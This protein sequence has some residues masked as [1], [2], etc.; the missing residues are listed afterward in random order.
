M[1]VSLSI[2]T[3]VVKTPRVKQLSSAF[4][5]PISEKLSRQWDFQLPIEDR[6]WNVGL[7]VGPSGSG[8]SQIARKIYGAD[9]V[10]DA[11]PWGTGAVVDDFKKELSIT[12]ITEVCSA[13]GFNTVPS[14][15]RPFRTLSNGEQFRVDL[16]RRMLEAENDKTIVVDEFSSVVDRQ[17]AKIASNSV[18]KYVR[19]KGKQFVAI[20]CHYDVIDWLQPD[21]VFEPSTCEFRWRSL[22]CRPRIDGEIRETKYESWKKFA[23]YHYMTADLNKSARCYVFVVDEQEVGFASILPRPVSGGKNKG[24]VIW[25]FSRV[26]VLPDWQGM[27][28]A[29]VL[30]NAISSAYKTCNMRVRAYPAHP[31]YYRSYV[32]SKEWKCVGKFGTMTVRNKTTTGT[33][34]AQ[35]FGGRDN[36]TFEYVGPAMEDKYT[37]MKIARLIK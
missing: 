4:Q 21:W 17:V 34:R 1:H 10:D 22:Q 28:I 18:Q 15:L 6:P 26:V 19:R 8:K 2:S 29:F 27:G 37:A 11:L 23:P 20:T 3:D 31:S 30:K 33:V 36:A 7:I 32:K 9:V 14:W 16:A 24:G 35:S 13:V 12:E 25:G 5:V